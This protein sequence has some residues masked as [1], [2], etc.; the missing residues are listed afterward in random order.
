LLSE[1]NP[2]DVTQERRRQIREEAIAQ[3]P[4]PVRRALE[5]GLVY[6]RINENEK[7]IEQFKKVL[8]AATSQPA[9]SEP[10]Y[11]YTIKVSP[12]R[13]AASRLFDIARETKNWD[14]VE[15]IV[16]TVQQYNLD[17]FQ[18]QLFAARVAYAKGDYNAALSKLDECIKQKPV[19]SQAYVLR[20]NV[21][22]ALG[23]EHSA[24]EDIRRGFSFNPMDSIAAKAL[25]N[26]L[27]AR[28]RKL[29][30]SVSSEQRAE[31]QRA[32]ETAIRLNPFELLLLTAYAE[33]ISTDEPLKAMALRQ[34][35]QKRSPTLRNAV[36][37]GKLA[38][39]IAVKEMDQKRKEAFFAVALSA[40]E[41]AKQ[42][43]PKDQ[44]ML[45][46]YAEYY[47]A[48]GQ[49]DKAQALL[50]ESKD[51]KLLWRHYLR[52]GRIDEAKK[53]LEQLYKQNS[54]ESDVLKGL[55]VVCE[56]YGDQAAV[57][58]YSEE[59]L[60][61]E[62]NAENR[63]GQLRAFLGIGLIKEAQLKLQSLKERYPNESRALLFEATLAM[64]QGQLKTALE[65]AN[66]NLQVNQGDASAWQLRGEINTL[67]G[68]Y[69]QAIDD[70]KRSKSLSDSTEARIALAQ[71]YI[72]A[73]RNDEAISELK[74]IIEKPDAS[75]EARM[76]LEGI[77]LRLGRKE[78]LKQFYDRTL[79]KL[80][81]N[82]HWYN[83]TAAFAVANAEFDR[84]EQLYR[85][86]YDLKRSEYAAQSPTD[87]VR[88]VDYITALDGYL[89]CLVLAAGE[90]NNA[91]KSGWHPEKLD[92]VFEEGGKYVDTAFAPIAFYRMAE[93]KFRVGDRQSVVD[94]CR[95]A[96]D[97][98]WSND[99]IAVEILMRTL[100]LVGPD[101]VS[102]YCEERLKASPD[103]MAANF[104]MYNLTKIRGEYDASVGYIDKCIA[105]AGPDTQLGIEHIMQRTQLLTVA[106]EKTSDN[107]Y[108]NAA[109]RDYESLLDKMPNNTTALNNLA[110]LLAQSN[111]KLSKA[112]EY[113]KRA[114]EL[115]PNDANFLDTYGYVL[116]K[117]GKNSE[118]AESLAAAIQQYGRGSNAP[119]EVYE[120]LGMAKEALGEKSQALAAYKRVLEVGADNLSAAAKQRINAAIDRLTQ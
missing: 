98:A 97:K 81:N 38:T 114:V 29:G 8:E 105:L 54:K 2:A 46:S 17:D 44:F 21:Q 47:R 84:A 82:V 5:A 49:Y 88:D 104:T 40:L 62:D 75:D 24:I 4:D 6:E 11:A 87:A 79:E 89:R 28:N 117:S 109:I 19:F 113:A 111:Q 69:D 13:T 51:D 91:Q 10:A 67:M 41:Q 71:A 53:V 68:S 56:Q 23:N 92:R 15:N 45:D 99:V 37:L 76:M 30:Q 35:L 94:Y 103:S 52:I 3:I 55:V 7:A 86:S 31:V 112:I 102:K 58:K 32:L 43:D 100:L 57:L 83:R 59:L 36:D 110:Y 39:R 33:Y 93:A 115:K 50:T 90:P 77:Y 18:G 72:W 34:T 70:F 80:P 9:V 74:S 118:S 66:R 120:H 26:A 106:Y 22:T 20:G 116:L 14:L 64:R 108:L 16:K 85:K 12:Q 73:G 107:R 63:I 61:V 78:T 27:Y 42:M 65:L 119:P 25:A 95:K 96:V 48:T 1:S 101:E 60:T